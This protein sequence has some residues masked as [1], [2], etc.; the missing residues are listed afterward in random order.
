MEYDDSP[1]SLSLFVRGKVKIPEEADYKD[2]WERVTCATIQTKYV[3]MRC[4]LNNSVQKTYKIKCI[5][6]RTKLI[7]Y[8]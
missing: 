4:N 7:Q 2:Q 6:M 3:T 5:Q 8:H 1:D